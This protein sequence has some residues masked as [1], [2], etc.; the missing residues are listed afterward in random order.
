M[1][2]SVLKEGEVFG[3]FSHIFSAF[4]ISSPFTV[5]TNEKTR[6]IQISAEAV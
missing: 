3:H 6:Y 5:K 2:F 4:N 1:L